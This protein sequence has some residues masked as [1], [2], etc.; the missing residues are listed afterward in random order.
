MNNLVVVLID[1]YDKGILDHIDKDDVGEIREF[2]RNFYGI[3]KASDPYLKFV[4]ITGIS[5]FT[6]TS[7]FSQLNNLDDLTL[8]DEYATICGFTF[9]E[10]KT[11]FDEYI[12]QLSNKY[13]ISYN[14]TLNRIKYWYNGYKFGEE[15]EKVIN[16]FSLLNCFDE[17]KFR[18]YWIES[19]TP[20]FI[21]KYL[22]TGKVYDIERFDGIKVSPNFLIPY[23]IEKAPPENF[24]FQ[25]GYLTILDAT[26]DYYTLGFPNVEVKNALSELVLMIGYKIENEVTIYIKENVKNGLLEND[27]EKLKNGLNKLFANIPY[28]LFD[29]KEKYYHSLI[30][31]S[32]LMCGLNAKNEE[33]NN[34]G[35]SDIVV[36]YFDNRIWIIEIKL[37]KSPDKAIDQIKEKQY[38]NKYVDKEIYLVGININSEKRCVEEIKFEKCIR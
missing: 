1:E 13:K 18:N 28:N 4:F 37:D 10:I 21:I 5:K 16:P 32:L 17:L 30:F 38:H 9:D 15:C 27:P 3:L 33:P 6:K 7:I 26:E 23:E 14:E 35:K 19:G 31:T 2:F 20:M 29:S 36:E 22:K 24:L 8:Y 12:K 34:L 25:A 11:Y